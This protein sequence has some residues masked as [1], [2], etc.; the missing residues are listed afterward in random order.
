MNTAEIKMITD[1]IYQI[2]GQYG[3]DQEPIK[4]QLRELCEN[5]LNN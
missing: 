2:L 1:S 4:S 5:L 3:E